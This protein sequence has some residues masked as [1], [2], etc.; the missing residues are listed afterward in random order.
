[1]KAYSK[2]ENV[3]EM[4]RHH[5]NR[6]SRMGNL[7]LEGERELCVRF[8]TSRKTLAKALDKL[9]SEQVLCRERQSTRIVPQNRQIGRY[10]YVP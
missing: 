10:A 8:G 1:M 2:Y 7:I 9:V 6:C 3:L 4:L 5:V